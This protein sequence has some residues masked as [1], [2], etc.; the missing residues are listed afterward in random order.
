MFK[1]AENKHFYREMDMKD[2]TDREILLIYA[3]SDMEAGWYSK[4]FKARINEY[5]KNQELY[6]NNYTYVSV[7][8]EEIVDLYIFFKRNEGVYEYQGDN[9]KDLRIYACKDILDY[10]RYVKDFKNNVVK[11]LGELTKEGGD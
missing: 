1:I 8:V 4:E 10:P 6:A 11:Y 7:G 2:E 9:I 5:V 3:C